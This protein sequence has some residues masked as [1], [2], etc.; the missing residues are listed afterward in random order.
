VWKKGGR[1]VFPGTLFYL[2][3]TAG[4][5]AATAKRL[6]LG[7]WRGAMASLLLLLCL[8][9][10]WAQGTQEGREH[11][12]VK[13]GTLYERGDFGT[14]NTT[15]VFFVPV[16]FRYL[17]ERFDVSVTPSFVRI[18]TSG[19][20]RLIDGVPIPTGEGPGIVREAG[21]GDTL[22][23]GRLFLLEDAG[24]G[25]PLSALTP[26]VKI[27]IPTANDK[28]DLGTGKADYGFGVEWDKQLE[29][30]LLFGDVGYTVIGKPVGLALQN[31]PAASFGVGKKASDTVTVSGLVDWRRAIV[32]GSQ[33]PV[34]LVG[35]LTYKATP[36]VSLSPNAF[37][38][39][40]NG[41]PA[42]GVGIEL[43]F[44]FGKF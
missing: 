40:T 7:R 17:G 15:R 25:S 22:V 6:R 16:T 26:F 27:K 1:L 23:K 9:Q 10:G 39:L 12:L 8:G 13:I 14:P 41:S 21:P 42:F 2:E 5:F 33:D 38:G 29:S 43:A 32:R 24:R 3:E 19:G 31:R 34:G 44:K 30:F 28:R 37:V 35:I 36:T 4:H 11:F 20:V 18:D